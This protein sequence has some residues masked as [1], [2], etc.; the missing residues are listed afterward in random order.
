MPMGNAIRPYSSSGWG[1]GRR[2]WRWKRVIRPPAQHPALP[3]VD[4]EKIRRTISLL[5]PRVT[6]GKFTPVLFSSLGLI[7]PLREGEGRKDV[8]FKAFNQTLTVA[9][10]WY[11][12]QFVLIQ[13]IFIFHWVKTLVEVL[14]FVQYQWIKIAELCKCIRTERLRWIRHRF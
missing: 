14:L 2:R 11:F 4:P 5:L 8:A 12:I 1:W 9:T 6:D 7:A 13:T 10:R 3:R